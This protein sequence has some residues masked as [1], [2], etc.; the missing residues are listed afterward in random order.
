MSAAIGII[1]AILAIFVLFKVL[2]I[3]LKIIAAIVLIG[4]AIAFYLWLQRRID[5][6]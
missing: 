5:R 4:I 3:I 1:L 2:S 6:R